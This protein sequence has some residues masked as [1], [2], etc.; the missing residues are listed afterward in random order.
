MDLGHFEW[1]PKKNRENRQKHGIN[2]TDVVGIFDKPCVEGLDER[3][4]YGEPRMIAYG[5]LGSHVVVVVF[6][7]RKDCRR[8]ISA[9]KA[10][11]S[12]SKVYWEIVYGNT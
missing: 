12:E 3:F 11:H 10:T 7:W 6:C 5:Q 4:N 2:F 1:D 8:I 9:R